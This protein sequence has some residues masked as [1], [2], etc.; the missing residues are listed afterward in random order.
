MSWWDNPRV[1]LF[2]RWP[3]SSGNAAV[4]P[5]EDHFMPK[6]PVNIF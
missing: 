1:S 3:E 6:Y 4:F 2:R 5:Q